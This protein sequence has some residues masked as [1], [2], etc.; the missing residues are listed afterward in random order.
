MHDAEFRED[1]VQIL[2]ET[3][4]AAIDGADRRDR[5]TKSSSNS[6]VAGGSRLHICRR[7]HVTSCSNEGDESKATKATAGNGLIPFAL[8]CGGSFD[9]AIAK[10]AREPNGPS[11]VYPVK[12][13]SV[14]HIAMALREE[15][16]RRSTPEDLCTLTDKADGKELLAITVAWVPRSPPS[17]RSAH[18]NHHRRPGGCWQAPRRV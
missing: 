17:G 10:E 2:K 14:G 12:T 8:A 18:Y 1:A 11:K 13:K 7:R 9:K 5:A 16:A 6:S 15:S 4:E 3:G